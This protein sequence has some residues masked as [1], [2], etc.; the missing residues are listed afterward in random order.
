MPNHGK[1]TTNCLSE[2]GALYVMFTAEIG[3]AVVFDSKGEDNKGFQ[4]NHHK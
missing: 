4:Q 2:S 3:T 1:D